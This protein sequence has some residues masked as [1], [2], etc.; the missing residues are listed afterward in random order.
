MLS[1][2]AQNGGPERNCKTL[3][4]SQGGGGKMGRG[5]EISNDRLRSL[6]I[7]VEISGSGNL[8]TAANMALYP[9]MVE[10]AA[11]LLLNM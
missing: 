6:R 1:Q 11:P 5:A 4:N 7:D 8:K 10:R 9:L 2:G 3:S